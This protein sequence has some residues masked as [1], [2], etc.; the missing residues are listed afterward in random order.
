M[1]QVTFNTEAVIR[2]TK[3]V[4]ANTDQL[5]YVISSVLNDAVFAARQVIVQSLWP[6][7]VQERNKP[8]ISASL[9][10]Q[11][12][13]KE[14]LSAHLYDQLKRGHLKEHAESGITSAHGHR[15]PI[16]NLNEI[17]RSG[18]GVRPGQRARDIIASTPAR[19]LRVTATA[20]F[21]AEGGRLKYKYALARNAKIKADVPFHE[22][23]TDV[24]NNT[25][26]TSFYPRLKKAME[27]RKG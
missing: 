13:T 16:P 15:M 10:V 19:Q 24:V 23:F 18:R 11:K 21:V 20:I 12:A 27:T 1:F 22:T 5:P 7:H 9:R 8:F 14:N 3:Q 4:G 26:R 6:S 2:A 25:M 17:K